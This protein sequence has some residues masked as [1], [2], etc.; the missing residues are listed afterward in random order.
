M[1]AY[2]PAIPTNNTQDAIQN[3]LNVTDVSTLNLLWLGNGCVTS[4]P[5]GFKFSSSR[6]GYRGTNYFDFNV[7]Y[8]LVGA[9]SNG[10]SQVRDIRSG[11]L[12][13]N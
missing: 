8:E 11:G 5:K 4:S 10:I 13:I 1:H 9:M 7:A 12:C 2:I 6:P 3:G